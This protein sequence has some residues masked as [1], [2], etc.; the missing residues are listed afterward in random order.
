[1]VRRCL[2]WAIIKFVAILT[3]ESSEIAKI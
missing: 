1:L 3:V 2:T